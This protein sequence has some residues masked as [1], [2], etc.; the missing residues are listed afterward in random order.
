[1][2]TKRKVELSPG[3]YV[4]YKDVYL[5]KFNGTAKIAHCEAWIARLIGVPPDAIQLV[6]PSEH[7]GPVT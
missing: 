4:N 1:M 3:G 2:K 5:R 6:L 7:H